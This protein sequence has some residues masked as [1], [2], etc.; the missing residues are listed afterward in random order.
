MLAEVK[1]LLELLDIN[2]R[3]QF[4]RIE[5]F[6]HL[7]TISSLNSREIKEFESISHCEINKYLITEVKNIKT[8]IKHSIFF[9]EDAVNVTRTERIQIEN[10]SSLEFDDLLQ[11]IEKIHRCQ[12]IQLH[13]IYKLTKK[14]TQNH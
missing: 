7:N 14:I 8:I 1:I 11:R 12:L 10:K 5:R 4:F 6:H 2:K 3:I 9:H 13:V